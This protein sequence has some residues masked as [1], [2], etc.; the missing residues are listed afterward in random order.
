M[1]IAIGGMKSAVRRWMLSKSELV[2]MIGA[3]LGNNSLRIA[4]VGVGQAR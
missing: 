2:E 1:A 3:E 4:R